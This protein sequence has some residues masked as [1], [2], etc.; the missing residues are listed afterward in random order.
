[1][2]TVTVIG[3][4]NLG[5]TYHLSQI[6][7]WGQTIA[8]QS[9]VFS[10]GGKG[11]NQAVAAR[12]FGSE[13]SFVGAVGD[14]GSGHAARRML[15]DAQIDVESLV[16]VEGAATGVG[17]I[18]L[19]PRGDNAIVIGAGANGLLSLE[20][21][22]ALAHQPWKTAGVVLAQ[23]EIPLEAVRCCFG[24]ARGIRILNPAPA[25]ADLARQ[26]WDW[27]DVLTPNESEAKLL[28]GMSVEDPV[29]GPD[30]LRAL[31]SRV[32][33]ASV[34]LTL[35]ERGSLVWHQNR[36]Y[37]ISSLSVEAV[38]TT[39]AGDVFNGILAAALSEGHTLVD[40]SVLASAGAALSVRTAG[41]VE[42]I[43]QREETEAQAVQITIRQRK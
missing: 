22:S 12:R 25:S 14:D 42:A 21:L 17:S 27:V 18:F 4:Y 29:D 1:M 10:H 37:E 39:G 2:G 3:S 32:G 34:V 8:S 13:V 7:V 31:A 41:V 11:S 15:A 33:K 5:I 30:L 9:A 40:A 43:P 24:E 23:L 6:P 26:S 19:G 36:I 20:R 38:D 35:G 28:A 16:T